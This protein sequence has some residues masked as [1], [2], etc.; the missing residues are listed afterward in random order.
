MCFRVNCVELL[1]ALLAEHL[2]TA[3]SGVLFLT[4]NMLYD[5]SLRL[6]VFGVLLLTL[7]MLYDHALRLECG[8]RFLKYIQKPTALLQRLGFVKESYLEKKFLT[9]QVWACADSYLFINP[10]NLLT[11]FDLGKII[12]KNKY[13]NTLNFY[14]MLT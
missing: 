10:C 6:A 14:N 12:L 3:V 4:L 1:K 7:N 5:H 8:D 11:D 2:R 13:K 9:S